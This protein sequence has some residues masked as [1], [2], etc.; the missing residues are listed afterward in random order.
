M[1]LIR[2][3]HNR[4]NPYAQI[5]RN[6][7]QDKRLSWEARGMLAY[8][9]SLPKDWEIIRK[10]LVEQ[11]PAGLDAVQAILD[12]LEQHNYLV[13]IHVQDEKGKFT[14]WDYFVFED[15]EDFQKNIIIIKE[16]YPRWEFPMLGKA[17]LGEP[18]EE[19]KEKNQK[20]KEEETE[21]KEYKEEICNKRSAPPHSASKEAEMLYTFFISSLKKR[22]ENF[23]EPSREKWLK[24]L[25]LLIKDRKGNIQEIQE[26]I[27]WSSEAKWYKANV[28]SPSGLRDKFS[29]MKLTKEEEEGKDVIKKN[30]N[31]ALTAKEQ[32]Q[33]ELGKIFKFDA[34]GVI[35]LSNGKDAQ[36]NLPHEQFKKI[37]LHIFDGEE[38]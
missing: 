3:A 5:A 25:D 31:F 34:E 22:D 18:K 7:I 13:K 8:M 26:V 28:L 24:E 17:H 4:E 11:S 15:V 32:H 2:K 37:F 35:N 38:V 29:K 21:K 10:N 20:N 14:G 12:E 30:M 33:E 36:F 19:E 1:C 6:T 16:K 23:K 9:L 27:V